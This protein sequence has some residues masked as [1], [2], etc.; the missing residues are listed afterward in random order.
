MIELSCTRVGAD[1]QLRRSS[2]HREYEG[3]VL[4]RVAAT[5]GHKLSDVP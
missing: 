5:A 4:R 2:V 3:G 1:G